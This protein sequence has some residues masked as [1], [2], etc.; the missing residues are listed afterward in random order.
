MA[1]EKLEFDEIAALCRAVLSPDE[2]RALDQTIMAEA[3][4]ELGRLRRATLP[5]AALASGASR[6]RQ[7]PKLPRKSK[8]KLV[9]A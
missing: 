8:I 1:I 3:M 6:S 2:V 7:L 9:G 4:T 5:A